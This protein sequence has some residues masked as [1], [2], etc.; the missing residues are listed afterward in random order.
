VNR[1]LTD[2]KKKQ[3][4][5]WMLQTTNK[6]FIMIRDFRKL[7]NEDTAQLDALIATLPKP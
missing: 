2:A 3:P 5:E 7:R 1:F 4:V 6:N